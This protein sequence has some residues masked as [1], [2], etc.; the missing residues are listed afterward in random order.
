MLGNDTERPEQAKQ[1]HF[2]SPKLGNPGNFC[3][4][5]LES[6]F[7]A[8]SGILGSRIRNTVQGIPMPL[9]IGIEIP[10]STGKELGIRYLESGVSGVES[11]I[12]KL[13]WVSIYRKGKFTNVNI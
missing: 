8:E 13:S 5:N 4:R 9:T 6:I 12:Q 2:I 11:R 7:L 3:W 1:R 10:S